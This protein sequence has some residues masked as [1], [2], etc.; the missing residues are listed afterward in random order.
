MLILEEM[1]IKAKMFLFVF[2][3]L[4]AFM[5]CQNQQYVDER[6]PHDLKSFWQ[7]I[8]W[9]LTS[10]QET[11]PSYVENKVKAQA[12]EE[13][14]AGQLNLVFINH[15]SFLIQVPGFNILT[16]PIFSERASPVSWTGPKRVRAPG[17]NLEEL[18]KIDVIVISHNHYDHMDLP[19][20]VKLAK[21]HDPFIIVPS[22]NSKH[23]DELKS[24]KIIELS[25]WQEHN[26]GQ[27]LKIALTPVR[28]WSARSL[29][30]KNESLWGG[31]LIQS[32]HE[33]KTF[34]VFF[35]GDTGYASW[36]KDIRDKYQE[37]DISLLPIGAYEPRWFMKNFHMDPSEAAQAHLDLGSAFSVGMHFETFQLT[38]E[39]YSK[40]RQALANALRDKAIDS[41]HF[42]CPEPGSSYLFDKNVGKITVLDQERVG[43]EY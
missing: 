14:P 42:L 30:D 11:W 32:K 34:K 39:A 37:I 35:A 13:V 8:K 19:S 26:L 31:Y 29:W 25:W 28:H 9:K 33:N 5:A 15:A 17:L 4:V 2:T 16:D 18:P 40:P 22:G 20:L 6:Y 41:K 27:D 7:V 36:F 10:E 38:D 3:F 43:N 21:D 12:R 1:K 24:K 23:L